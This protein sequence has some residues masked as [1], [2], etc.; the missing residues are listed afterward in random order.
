MGVNGLIWIRIWITS[1]S[2]FTLEPEKWIDAIR[3]GVSIF[4][5]HAVQSKTAMKLLSG[6]GIVLILWTISTLL[7]LSTLAEVNEETKAV[8]REGRKRREQR[9]KKAQIVRKLMRTSRRVKDGAVRL[10]DG[11]NA[12]EGKLELF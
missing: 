10:V 8:A 7:V 4:K 5:V 6:L 1:H 2:T 11:S 9:G 3:A 12:H